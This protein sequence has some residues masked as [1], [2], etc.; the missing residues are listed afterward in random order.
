[1]FNRNCIKKIVVMLL[2]G[3][4]LTA[5]FGRKGKIIATGITVTK[6]EEISQ[7]R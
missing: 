1:M 5:K 4:L 3:P 2:L 6:M 7:S